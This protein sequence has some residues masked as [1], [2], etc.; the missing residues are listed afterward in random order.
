MAGPPDALGE[1]GG[2][3]EHLA[4]PARDDRVRIGAGRRV[5]HAVLPDLLHLPRPA[6]DDEMQS[7]AGLDHH[8]LL[9]EDTDLPLRREVHDRVAAFIADRREVLEVIAAALRR[10]CDLV[11]LLTQVAG[12]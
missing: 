12:M 5:D 11:P 4:V 1:A 2:D 3:R 6:P 10:D 7:F 9:A 8:E